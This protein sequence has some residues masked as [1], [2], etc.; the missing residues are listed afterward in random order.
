MGRGTRSDPITNAKIVK[1]YAELRNIYAVAS[2]SKCSHTHVIRVLKRAG[3]ERGPQNKR[4][5][6]LGD[7]AS[8]TSDASLLVPT[9]IVGGLYH[10]MMK[11][12]GIRIRCT[13][14]GAQ[15]RCWRIA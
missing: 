15:T 7:I 8:L 1:R 12:H 5:K 14:E 13:R 2:L 11:E 6:V 10:R 3:V 9:D 4:A